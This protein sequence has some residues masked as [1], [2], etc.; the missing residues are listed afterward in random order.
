MIDII[1]VDENLKRGGIEVLDKIKGKKAWIDIT[2][3]TAP[4]A[5]QLGKIFELHPLTV[6][7]LLNQ[8]IRIKVEEFPNYLLCVFYGIEQEESIE[9]VEVDFLI[10]EDYLI[11]NHKKEIKSFG[12][13]KRNEE[14]LYN[15]FKR[16]CDFVFHRLLDHEVDNYFPVL[17]TIDDQIDDIEEEVTKNPNP[18]LL[19]DIL[20]IKRRI[21]FIKKST[22]PQ[23]EKIGFLAKNDYRYIS[24]KAI[25]YFRD[26]YDHAIR[27][28]DSID[29]YREA[30]GG[31]FDAYMSA[32]SNRMNEVMKVLSIIATI[33]LPLTVVSGIYGTNFE[34][35]PGASIKYGFWLMMLVMVLIAGS[36]MYFFKKRGWY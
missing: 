6:E 25:P 32:V 14:K 17:E 16:G 22:L 33:A 36:M 35:L 18:E 5:E 9:L 26:I 1:Y 30:I 12:E 19:N 29:N 28:S 13:L 31:S 21:S 8:G 10:G 15:L 7:D 20:K 24:K 27:V 11:T 23:R 34:V 3:I 4:E 2:D